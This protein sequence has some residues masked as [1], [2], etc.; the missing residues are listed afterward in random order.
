M[1]IFAVELGGGAAEERISGHRRKVD[2]WGRKRWWCCDCGEECA[3]FLAV[4]YV[5]RSQSDIGL[6]RRCSYLA[7]ASH[8]LE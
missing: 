1:L 5:S 6:S 8:S 7:I 3:V 2:F 4:M